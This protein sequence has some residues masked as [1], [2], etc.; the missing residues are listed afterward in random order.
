M[1][2]NHIKTKKQIQ[3]GDYD[4]L[5]RI[6]E[7][8]KNELITMYSQLKRVENTKAWKM[9]CALRRLNEQFLKAPKSEKRKFLRWTKNK[10]LKK[11]INKELELAQFSP[12]KSSNFEIHDFEIIQNTDIQHTDTVTPVPL[13]YKKYDTP[14]NYDVFRFPVIEWDF[15]WQRPQQIA[16]QFA[17]YGHRVFYFSINTEGA[18]DNSTY[19]EVVNNVQIKELR[20]NVWWVKLCTSKS[21]N[22]YRD[23][24]NEKDLLFLKWSLDYLKAKFSISHTISI[25]DLPFWTSLVLEIE[26]NITLYDCMDDHAGFSTNSDSMLLQEKRLF[27]DSDIVVATSQRLYEKVNKFNDNCLLVRNAGEYD[28]FSRMPKTISKD[29]PVGKGPIIGY[30]GAISE[31]FDIKLIEE[32]AKRNKNWT[33]VLVG[34]TFGCSIEATSKLSNVIFTGEKPYSELTSYLYGFD[35]CLI[36]FLVN[37]LTL[38]TN[39]VKVYEYLAAGK[40]VVSTELPELK[41]MSHLVSLATTVEDFEEAIKANLQDSENKKIERM[42]FAEN[43]SWSARYKQ[44]SSEIV[45]RFY[46]K[47]S[48][49]IVTYNNWSFTKQCLDSLFANSDYPNLEI[50]V[51]DNASQDETRIELSKIIHPQLKVILS[52]INEGFAG[53]N[54]R[55]IKES[56]GDYIILLNN[57]TIVPHGWVERLINPLKLTN[58]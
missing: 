42:K 36:P 22:A 43:N 17:D 39:P 41:V 55:G 33:F 13:T 30:Y 3:Y 2:N 50:I 24:I 37:E 11:P 40:P 25:V 23:T 20:K 47:I 35:V 8:N 31:W 9:M 48:I 29:I 45:A 4:S 38:A 1:E 12:L 58:Y 27:E 7:L 34:D 28:Y 54:N 6:N 16:S 53:G 52:P 15:R 18:N 5:V 44:L 14:I 32:L 19:E 49:V 46:P 10:I 21:L 26:K 51:V 57:D 56:T